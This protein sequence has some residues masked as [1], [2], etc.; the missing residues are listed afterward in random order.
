M[1]IKICF[2]INTANAK[3][4]AGTD[5]PT[6]QYLTMQNGKTSNQ[7]LLHKNL[8][9]ST[10]VVEGVKLKMGYSPSRLAYS[11]TNKFLAFEIRQL[12]A[13]IKKLLLKVLI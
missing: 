3:R 7:T 9:L 8:S 1:V 4:G 11:F 13:L 5:P 2:H 6:N 10:R 12:T